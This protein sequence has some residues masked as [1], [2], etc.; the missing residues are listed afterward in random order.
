MVPDRGDS[1]VGQPL[2]LEIVSPRKHRVRQLVKS[3]PVCLHFHLETDRHR[4]VPR[5]RFEDEVVVV[6]Q[7]K[8]AG[9]HTKMKAQRPAAV[10]GCFRQ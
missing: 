4:E 10:I 3:R 6:D 8:L 1:D 9:A 7:L 2:R 5:R